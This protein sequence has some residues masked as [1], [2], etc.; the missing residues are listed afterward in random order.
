MHRHTLPKHRPCAHRQLQPRPPARASVKPCPNLIEASALPAICAYT[1]ALALMPLAALLQ[2]R[3][4]RP[5]WWLV[6]CLH[7]ECP[8]LL[9]QAR[10]RQELLLQPLQLGP[11][12]KPRTRLPLQTV[13][14][15]LRGVQGGSRTR[16]GAAAAKWNICKHSVTNG[17]ESA[18][19]QGGA[20]CFQEQGRR[21]IA[22]LLACIGCSSGQELGHVHTS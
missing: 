10:C 4:L 11:Q 19:Q 17:G 5:Q 1:C 6:C 15:L 9:Q 13:A 8:P 21:V 22:A 12:A 20:Q 2:P 7:R 3:P 14:Q 18:H 16:T